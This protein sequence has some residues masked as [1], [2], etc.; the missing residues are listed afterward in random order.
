MTTLQ[1]H[2][3][4]I[5]S[6]VTVTHMGV[7]PLPT[8]TAH[9]HVVFKAICHSAGTVD[10]YIKFFPQPSPVVSPSSLNCLVNSLAEQ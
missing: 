10:L 3:V 6:L 1:Y 7:V 8:P 2:L 5:S 4:C 9:D